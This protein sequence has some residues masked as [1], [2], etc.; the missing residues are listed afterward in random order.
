MSCTCPK[1]H[2]LPRF[3]DGRRLRSW[4]SGQPFPVGVGDRA[5]GRIVVAV[6]GDAVVWERRDWRGERS[7]HGVSTR[8]RWKHWSRTGDE[9]IDD[10][11]EFFRAR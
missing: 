7:Q 6:N 5:F 3:V 9:L 11:R 1:G 8:S 10:W 4:R 2:R